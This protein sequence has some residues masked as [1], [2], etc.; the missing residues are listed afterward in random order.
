MKFSALILILL[1]GLFCS[2]SM[3][4]DTA[5]TTTE[6]ISARELVE[7]NT[8]IDVPDYAVDGLPDS[9]RLDPQRIAKINAAQY[10]FIRN[11]EYDGLH[12]SINIASGSEINIDQSLF[13]EFVKMYV[14]DK[15][16]WIDRMIEYKKIR[17]EKS[18][19]VMT[20]V[21]NPA[22]RECL[23]DGVEFSGVIEIK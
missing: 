6:V 22:Y 2:C 13:D 1:S 23:L 20:D 3:D 17:G 11:M 14:T 19:I 12:Y 5:A 4:C 7:K 8:F 16:E 21:T 10:R 9:I 15:N 18:K